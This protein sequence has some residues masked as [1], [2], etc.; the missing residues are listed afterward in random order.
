MDFIE[1]LKEV[2]RP[3]VEEALIEEAKKESLKNLIENFKKVFENSSYGDLNPKRRKVYGEDTLE[4]KIV[5]EIKSGTGNNGWNTVI[6]LRRKELDDEW[7]VD[8]TAEVKCACPAFKYYTSNANFKS[9][10]FYG[11]PDKWARTKPEKHNT[12]GTPTMCKH[13]MKAAEMAV[14]QDLINM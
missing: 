12:K 6:V 9:K 7:N 10:N 2:L 5:T 4:L 14:K 13:L 1:E 3:M 8:M 11:R